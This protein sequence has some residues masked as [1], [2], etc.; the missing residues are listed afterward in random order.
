MAK[1]GALAVQVQIETPPGDLQGPGGDL[2]ELPKEVKVKDAVMQ[3][4]EA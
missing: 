4:H 3:A 1:R 2:W